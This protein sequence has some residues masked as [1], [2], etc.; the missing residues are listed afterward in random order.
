MPSKTS[1]DVFLSH[2]HAD[3]DIVEKLAIKLNDEAKMNIWLDKW[4]LVPGQKWQQEMARG[5]T[6]AKAC[7][8]CIGS[9]TPRG[10]FQEEI[11]R[12]L[13]QQVQK[14]NFGVIP[15]LL[16]GADVSFVDDFLELRTWVDFRHG[17]EDADAF[18]RLISG[19]MGI[20]PG[21]KTHTSTSNT[22]TIKPTM[23]TKF[24]HDTQVW[25]A[26]FNPD[27]KH[28]ASVSQDGIYLWDMQLK[29]K[30]EVLQK[31][32]I[33]IEGLDME[34]D[35]I[36]YHPK[37][38]AIAYSK[39]WQVYF[40]NQQI[41]RRKGWD[42]GIGRTVGATKLR[43]STDGKLLVSSWVDGITSILDVNEKKEKILRT[44]GLNDIDISPNSK[45]LATA[46]NGSTILLFSIGTT[47]LL[48]TLL[49]DAKAIKCIR[50]SSNEHL[51]GYTTGWAIHLM[52]ISKKKSDVKLT[53]HK[54]IVKK[55]AFNKDGTLLASAS[56]DKSVRLWDLQAGKEIGKPLM[57]DGAVFSIAFSEDGK[58]LA[59]ACQDHHVWLWSLY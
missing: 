33:F 56:I 10:W 2:S 50:F 17:L 35:Y 18:H 12:A 31:D 4:V 13:N 32:E 1:F 53:G 36:T 49:S 47:K 3:A 42:I 19:I 29:I 40:D 26:I 41:I 57:H 34:G 27:G 38:S 21:R 14:P 11:E 54:G 20:S 55:I 15:V 37:N 22:R 7:I 23:E 24:P 43:F 8:I 59:S 52:D 51:L 25:N 45:Y 48:E 58:Y 9:Q 16:P 44:E 28:L 46:I 39:G 5:I 6:Q 30:G